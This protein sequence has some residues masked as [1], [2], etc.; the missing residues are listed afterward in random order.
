MAVLFAICFVIALCFCTGKK[1]KRLADLRDK[2]STEPKGA[3]EQA[4]AQPINS[5]QADP[6]ASMSSTPVQA[7]PMPVNVVYPPPTPFPSAPDVM[8]AQ[9]LREPMNPVYPPIV[10]EV[11]HNP[12]HDIYIYIYIWC[13]IGRSNAIISS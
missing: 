9:A 8:S 11:S 3:S 6:N 2:T 1:T 10:E 4:G 12:H 7:A 13:S 5:S